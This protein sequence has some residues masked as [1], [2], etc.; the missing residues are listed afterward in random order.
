[1]L[2]DPVMK[3]SE[4]VLGCL[5][6]QSFAELR[7]SSGSLEKDDQIASDC[8]CHRAAEVLFQQRQNE[9]DPRP[10]SV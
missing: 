2:A 10:R 9:I 8:E 4:L 3:R 5:K 1:M 6:G 7:L